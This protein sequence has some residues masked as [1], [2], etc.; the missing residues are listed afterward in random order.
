MQHSLTHITAAATIYHSPSIGYSQSSI[1]SRVSLTLTITIS[2]PITIAATTRMVY[3]VRNLYNTL[4]PHIRH[5]NPLSIILHTLSFHMKIFST[6]YPHTSESP[7][8]PGKYTSQ[9]SLLP[10][11]SSLPSYSILISNLSLTQSLLT[12]ISTDITIIVKCCYN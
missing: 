5:S 6:S 2:T 4:Y 1:S 9:F 8:I 10:N 11:P 3:D 7:S 12:I